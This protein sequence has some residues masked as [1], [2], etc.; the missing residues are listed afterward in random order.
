VIGTAAKP[1]FN[2]GRILVR[3]SGEWLLR[4]AN[5]N[6]CRRAEKEPA[7]APAPLPYPEITN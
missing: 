2:I 6:S 1:L 3:Q 7:G 4:A 5:G